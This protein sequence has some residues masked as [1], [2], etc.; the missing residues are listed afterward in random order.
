MAVTSGAFT[1]VP[2]LIGANRDEGASF[3][4][5]DVDWTQT[6]FEQ[7]VRDSYG[8]DADASSER[9][10]GICTRAR[11][12]SQR[13]P[14][15]GVSACMPS[16]VPHHGTHPEPCVAGRC[17]RAGG[18]ARGGSRGF[19]EQSCCAPAARNDLEPRTEANCRDDI[20]EPYGRSDGPSKNGIEASRPAGASR[21]H[22]TCQ[23]HAMAPELVG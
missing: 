21:E 13:L 11:W 19:V 20:Q 10:Q 23:L 17:T 5:G 8:P 3:T 6:Q 18:L 4:Q 9:R 14:G 7:W 2:V 16:R 15:S 22:D 12:A 1:R